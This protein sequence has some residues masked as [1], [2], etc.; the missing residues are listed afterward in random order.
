MR[1][2]FILRGED[3]PLRE[4][5]SQDPTAT[6]RQAA[7]HAGTAFRASGSRRRNPL[8]VR[9]RLAAAACAS[10]VAAAACAA[11]ISAPAQAASAQTSTP[12]HNEGVG[13]SSAP[14]SATL[15]G[16]MCDSGG[17]GGTGS[18]SG[19]PRVS[20][21]IPWWA[22]P[23]VSVTDITDGC[24]RITA[25]GGAES[26][27]T[28]IGIK[29][30]DPLEPWVSVSGTVWLRIAMSSNGTTH[31]QAGASVSLVNAL[32]GLLSDL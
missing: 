13:W 19:G 6:E 7:P 24:Y 32:G 18:C 25:Y 29:V 11:A 12:C 4:I 27:W 16:S 28:N 20:Y 14:F 2:S 8:R 23:F 15:T 21:D 30:T 3:G 31:K 17:T 9:A 22:D 5:E 10:F 1:N 26:M